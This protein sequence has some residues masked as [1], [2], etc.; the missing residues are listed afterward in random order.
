MPTKTAGF[1]P[2]CLYL[3]LPVLFWVH[4]LHGCCMAVKTELSFSIM[5]VLHFGLFCLKKMSVKK[6]E[7]NTETVHEEKNENGM[8]P[9]FQVSCTTTTCWYHPSLSL[10]FIA[11]K[12]GTLTITIIPWNGV[13]KHIT[14]PPSLEPRKNF[15]GLT[16]LF[17]Q[18]SKN[19]RKHRFW[20]PEKQR[21]TMM[22][23]LPFTIRAVAEDIIYL[24]FW[25]LLLIFLFVL[26]FTIIRT[27][28]STSSFQ[29]F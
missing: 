25:L 28:F 15:F 10:R 14:V 6:Q 13:R 12:P 11:L 26:R 22:W 21:A 5:I 19:S 18:P 1:G 4:C 24:L 3:W 8:Y 16:H 29:N 9:L 23:A 7:L 20:L 2:G 27:A 17:E